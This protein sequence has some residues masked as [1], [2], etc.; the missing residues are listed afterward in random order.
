MRVLVVTSSPP[1]VEGGHM[2]IAREIVQACRVAGHDAE[3]VVTPQNRFG[4]QGAAYLATWLTDVGMAADGRSVDHVVSLRYPSFAVR[5]P[6]HT[7]WLNHTMREYYDLWDRFADGLSWKNRLKEGVRRRLIHAADRYLLTSNVTHLFAQSATVQ[8]RLQRWGSIPAEVL[9][10]PAPERAYRC[11][12]Y[13]DYVFAVSRLTPLKRFDLLLD[14]LAQ[15]AASGVR[16]VIAG[17]GEA[18]EALLEQRR[19]LGLEDRVEFAGRLS[20]DALLAHYARCRAVAFVPVAEDYGFVTAEAFASGK[21]VV[22][23]TD[24]GG[25]TE[26][27]ADGATGRVVPPT[28]A[29]VAEA[30]AAVMGDTAAAEAMGAAARRR[31]S[32]LTWPATVARLLEGPAAG[33]G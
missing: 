8:A 23:C 11:D 14:A 26:L 19:R 3:V 22:T 25:P 24:S 4:R 9:H 6:S 27:V 16:L 13:G 10:P 28:A 31:V 18:R 17:D 15:P 12:G 32:A 30:L 1:F 7:C 33:R 20:E 5:H 21:A 29:G 2:V